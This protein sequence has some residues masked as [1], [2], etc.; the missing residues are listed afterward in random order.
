LYL[1]IDI[2]NTRIKYQYWDESG[3]PL[4]AGFVL[5]I[6]EIEGLLSGVDAIAVSNVRGIDLPRWRSFLGTI[7]NITGHSKLPFGMQYKTPETLGSDR[8]A[9]IAGA[10]K[11][12]P[13]KN[14]LC[15]DAGTCLKF[16][17]LHENGI[18]FGG[19]ISPGL[20]M[21]YKAL[22]HYTGK[23]PEVNHRTLNEISGQSTEESI[24]VGVQ[25]GYLG[26]VNFRIME[27]TEHFSNLNVILTGGDTDFLANRLKSRIFAEPL[28]LHH[29]LLY[30]LLTQ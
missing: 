19:S 26:E 29:G 15:I 13:H 14:V 22:N 10:K 6:W 11:L 28:L 4:K 20:K 30:C 18:Y 2:G 17:F 7:L 25:Q 8:I 24:L 21:R 12:Y 3:L 9:A 1:T 27:F 23:L 5:E 16:D